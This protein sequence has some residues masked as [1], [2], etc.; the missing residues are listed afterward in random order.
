MLK[1]YVYHAL[2]KEGPYVYWG[3]Y[4]SLEEARRQGYDLQDFFADAYTQCYIVI[5]AYDDSYVQ[6]KILEKA[7]FL[8]PVRKKQ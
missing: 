2:N 7:E 4:D 6:P 1:Y 5:I 8:T 3:N